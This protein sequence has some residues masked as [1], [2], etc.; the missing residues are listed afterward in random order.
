MKKK[1][2]YK[3]LREHPELFETTEQKNS[4]IDDSNIPPIPQWFYDIKEKEQNQKTKKRTSKT[5]IAIPTCVVI[6]VV[7]F[8]TPIGKTLADGL[9][10]LFVKWSSN[11][12]EAHY[13]AAEPSY[14]DDQNI[15]YESNTYDNLQSVKSNY[16]EIILASN[17]RYELAGKINV[18][19]NEFGIETNADYVVGNGK[20]TIT[21][22]FYH[23]IEEANFVATSDEED[24]RSIDVIVNNG[25]QVVG[26]FDS[27]SGIAVAYYDK[28]EVFFS[29]NSISYDEFVEFIKNSIIS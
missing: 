13:G 4:G 29:T 18:T 8:L 9:Y 2:F 24:A 26:Y 19:E 5:L 28:L 17:D 11:G 15:K 16:P 23:K 3:K 22:F 10:N 21:N 14:F 6:V 27:Q 25:T 1:E 20:A 12:V 7:L